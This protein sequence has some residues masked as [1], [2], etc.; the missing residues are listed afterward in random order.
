MINSIFKICRS[1]WFPRGFH[2]LTCLHF[3]RAL[4]TFIFLRVFIFYAPSFFYMPYVFIF[5]VTFTCPRTTS[6]SKALF[7]FQMRK[8]KRFFAFDSSPITIEKY[9]YIYI[10]IY[11]MLDTW[12]LLRVY[13]VLRILPAN[14][15]F[16]F[17]FFP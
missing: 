1:F 5:N 9:I 7:V 2:H 16:F 6:L 13:N 10:Y 11:I 17:F 15:C 12:Q 4:R 14:G 3:L 8:K